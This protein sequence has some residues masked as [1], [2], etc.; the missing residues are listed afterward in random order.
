MGY[1]LIGPADIVQWINVQSAGRCE[2]LDCVDGFQDLG[3]EEIGISFQSS[4]II[5]D[6]RMISSQRKLRFDIDGTY[7]KYQQDMRT[8]A[9]DVLS[10]H[11]VAELTK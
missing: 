4:D 1:L 2:V 7:L 11:L 6:S 8:T 9:H 3:D 5:N 10:N